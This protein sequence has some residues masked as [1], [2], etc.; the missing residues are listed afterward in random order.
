MGLLR[1]LVEGQGVERSLRMDLDSLAHK[2]QQAEL[3][4]E[5]AARQVRVE[6]W[7]VAIPQ[8]G[9]SDY[10]LVLMWMEGGCT[11]R[12]LA[13]LAVLEVAGTEEVM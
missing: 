3:L 2:V 1:S 13:E 11:E 4:V 6:M 5:Q 12:Y 7:L 8:R 9:R 10:L